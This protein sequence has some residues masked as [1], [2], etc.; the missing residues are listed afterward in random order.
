MNNNSDTERSRESTPFFDRS[1]FKPKDVSTVSS[2][3]DVLPTAKDFRSKTKE[4]VVPI[5]PY[6]LH[7]R[8]EEPQEIFEIDSISEV[9]SVQFD[10]QPPELTFSKKLPKRSP[11]HAMETRGFFGIIDS[12]YIDPQGYRLLELK[13]PK[14]SHRK[15]IDLKAGDVFQCYSCLFPHIT[16][17]LQVSY[18]TPYKYYPPGKCVTCIY[19]G[20]PNDQW[21]KFVI[22]IS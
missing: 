1:R 8:E 11:F 19:A 6:Q 4:Q 15:I 14:H 18:V 5:I 9:S 20:V 22:N 2:T 10:T 21:T 12:G 13:I 17:N 16:T 7:M 3:N